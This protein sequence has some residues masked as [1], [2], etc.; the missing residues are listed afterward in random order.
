MPLLYSGSGRYSGGSGRC[1]QL[2]T[3]V[4]RP[5]PPSTDHEDYIVVTE[6]VPKIVE[7]VPLPR[8]DKAQMSKKRKFSFKHGKMSVMADCT[9]SQG[10]KVVP[11]ICVQAR[12]ACVYA[13]PAVSWI[14][15]PI[16]DT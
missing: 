12:N 9:C 16:P 8:I 6:P 15:R 5:P 10:I 7:D 3:K 14:S 1:E 4:M 2:C 13:V 11:E